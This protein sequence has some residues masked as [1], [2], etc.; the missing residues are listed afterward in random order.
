[1]KHVVPARKKIESRTIFNLLGPLA[2]PIDLDYQLIGLSSDDHIEPLIDTV[3]T[4]PIKKSCFCIGG[5]G[6][7]EVSLIGKTKF[8]SI[9]NGNVKEFDFD[10]SKEIEVIKKDYKCGDSHENA[11][12]F[13]NLCIEDDWEHPIIKH[14]SIN[15]AA[16]LLCAGN[17][18]SLIEGYEKSMN[19]FKS[20]EVVKAINTYKKV[21]ATL[22]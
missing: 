20:Q 15:A 21:A 14:I 22:N 1:M 16:A 8:I 11:L 9:E 6:R 10:F 12:T 18:T 4:L 2:N 7:D 3:K 13:I 19:L 5:D 17:V